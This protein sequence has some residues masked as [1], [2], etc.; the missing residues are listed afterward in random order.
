MLSPSLCLSLYVSLFLS[1]F[2]SRAAPDLCFFHGTVVLEIVHPDQLIQFKGP[3]C[4]LPSS[5]NH[6]GASEVSK[7]W[8]SSRPTP[9]PIIPE[10][11]KPPILSWPCNTQSRVQTVVPVLPSPTPDLPPFRA[12][13]AKLSHTFSTSS[14]SSPALANFRTPFYQQILSFP[15]WGQVLNSA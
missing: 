14:R 13:S 9:L 12:P 7:K 5:K 1:L 15:N 2:L 10:R 6:N 3:S 8:S 4:F 11:Q